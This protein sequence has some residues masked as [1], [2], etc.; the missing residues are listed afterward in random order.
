[1]AGMII[2][3]FR[4]RKYFNSYTLQGRRYVCVPVCH[5]N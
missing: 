4:W 1:M 3:S 2:H 5:D